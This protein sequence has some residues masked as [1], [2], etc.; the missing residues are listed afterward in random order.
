MDIS[1]EKKEKF[2]KNKLISFTDADEEVT[3]YSTF[4]NWDAKPMIPFLQFI[5]NVDESK[6]NFLEDLIERGKIRE[7]VKQVTMMNMKELK[8][9]VETINAYRTYV[10][11]NW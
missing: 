6:P 3:I 4:T 9:Y 11:V 5:E 7:H 1:P 10:K 2:V 8:V